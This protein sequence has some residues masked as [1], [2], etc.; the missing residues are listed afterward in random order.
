MI[1]VENGDR[2][3]LIGPPGTGKTTALMGITKRLLEQGW[4]SEDFA[5]VS[6]TRAA[7]GEVKDRLRQFC[8]GDWSGVT[9]LHSAALQLSGSANLMKESDWM[10]FNHLANFSLTPENDIAVDYK[11][12]RALNTEDDA[13]RMVHGYARNK[14]VS[15][16]LARGQSPFTATAGRLE[17]F[18]E[19]LRLYKREMGVIDFTDLIESCVSS[20]S[21]IRR[22]IV[23]ID[24]AQDLSPLQIAFLEPTIARA[25]IVVVAGDDDQAIFEFQGASP[26]WL[27]SLHGAD[28]WRTHVLGKSWRCPEKVRIVAQRIIGMA[29]GR[30]PKEY[31]S[32]GEQGAVSVEGIGVALRNR[33]DM[34]ENPT[35]ILCRAGKQC[36]Q[37]AGAL[38][39]L[40]VPYVA[41]RGNG[42]KPYNNTKAIEAI[43]L[44]KRIGSGSDVSTA[45][46]ETLVGKFCRSNR[47]DDGLIPH[48]VKSKLKKLMMVKSS[49]S[50][51]E[52]RDLGCSA[53]VDVCVSDP[54]LAFQKDID[55][56]SIWYFR[57]MWDRYGKLPESKVTVTTWHSSKGRES[58]T[59]IVWGQ[60]PKPCYKALRHHHHRE[61]EIRSAYVAVTR[62]KETLVLCPAENG[63]PDFELQRFA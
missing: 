40:G 38:F 59:V 19:L 23:I 13:V 60:I 37:I 58:N 11:A 33:C 30:V 52:L 55:A 21:H 6:F 46:L 57:R 62:A 8:D 29:T 63:K 16:D 10:K 22:P 1:S 41:E 12:E 54:F 2:L 48:G 3:L 15:F 14:M 32:T 27:R 61:A 4:D 25:S 18:D 50:V 42:P 7:V 56:K 47:H 43:E 51:G 53:L 9:T 17:R 5:I 28:G 34:P 35:M 20:G 45:D 24:E 39:D 49:I 36:A 44:F 31:A 26:E